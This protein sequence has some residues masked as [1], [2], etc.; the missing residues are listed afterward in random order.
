MYVLSNAGAHINPE[1]ICQDVKLCKKSSYSSGAEDY[2]T[3]LAPN[4]KKLINKLKGMS[5]SDIKQIDQGMGNSFPDKYLSLES[6]ILV[7]RTV[8]SKVEPRGGVIRILQL[9][10]IHIDHQYDEV[11]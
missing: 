8:K 3:K 4:V 10:D 6:K 7:N 1:A 2:T 5:I 9:T 11:S